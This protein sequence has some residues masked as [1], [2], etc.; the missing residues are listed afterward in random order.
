MVSRVISEE[1]ANQIAF[2]GESLGPLF[3]H[4]PKLEGNAIR[5]LFEAFVQMDTQ[6]AAKE[7]PFTE[8]QK[9][10]VCIHEIQ[11]G[12]VSG[13]EDQA[14]YWEYRRL[15][16][17][18]QKKAAPPWGSVYMDREQV[19]FGS[20]T[21]RLHDWMR[22]NGIGV[23]KGTSDEPEDHLGTLL[24]MMAYIARNKPEVLIEYLQLHVLTWSSH[25]LELMQNEAHHPFD[26]GLASLARLSLEGIQETLQIEV[27]YPRYYR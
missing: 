11:K 1:I 25:F 17:G 9:A 14:L 26:H 16:V 8:D 5:S 6:E 22:R 10:A 2:I 3:T 7:W 24:L 23:K 18:P 20:T 13:F 19:I 12:L 4:D 27:V 21:M 15:F